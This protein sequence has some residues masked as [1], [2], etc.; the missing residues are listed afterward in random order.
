MCGKK[1]LHFQDEAAEKYKNE[2]MG[3]G[4]S[5]HA[6]TKRSE[7]RADRYYGLQWKLPATNNFHVYMYG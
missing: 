6:R 3:G 2:K 7:Y 1:D 5:F 4:M